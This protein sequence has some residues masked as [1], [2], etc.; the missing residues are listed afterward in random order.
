MKFY[1]MTKTKGKA[2]CSNATWRVTEDF[3]TKAELKKRKRDSR[4][5]VPYVHTEAE[6]IE[7]WGA[8]NAQRIMSEAKPY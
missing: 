8:E 5:S 7:T 1:Y 4:V 6:L 3:A 2:G